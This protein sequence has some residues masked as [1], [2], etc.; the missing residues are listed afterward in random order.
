MDW[1]I[2]NQK[3]K[4]KKSKAGKNNVTDRRL[5]KEAREAMEA[6]RARQRLIRGAELRSRG[7]I[8]ERDDVDDADSPVEETQAPQARVVERPNSDG[9]GTEAEDHWLRFARDNRMIEDGDDVDLPDVPPESRSNGPKYWLA[10]KSSARRTNTDDKDMRAVERLAAQGDQDAQERLA[11]VRARHTGLIECW[12]G[13]VVTV[14]RMH[15][16]G[17]DAE[18]GPA[19]P[20]EL[21]KLCELCARSG[22]P[23]MDCDCDQPPS[24]EEQRLLDML[25]DDPDQDQDIEPR[26]NARRTR[27]RRN[28]RVDDSEGPTPDE[29]DAWQTWLLNAL[30]FFTEGCGGNGCANTMLNSDSQVRMT[31]PGD[32]GKDIFV[33]LEAR[34][35]DL[36]LAFLSV[37]VQVARAVVVRKQKI[38]NTTVGLQ[39][40]ADEVA[41]THGGVVFWVPFPM[42]GHLTPVGGT[43]GV[44][45]ASTIKG[46][47]FA[48]VF[49]G[50]E[51]ELREWIRTREFYGVSLLIMDEGWRMVAW[52]AVSATFPRLDGEEI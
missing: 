42:G 43:G 27:L 7:E 48:S 12:C 37:I 32:M 15:Y 35:M 23:G 46:E 25:P 9:R 11:R 5:R 33:A 4:K 30:P 6:E 49:V 14:G 28:K 3:K 20:A 1:S 45:F 44:L 52:G 38:I 24:D 21:G 2:G 16:P 17:L 40:I 22:D 41:K 19:H 8:V 47:A 51:V 29:R 18:N 13:S 34:E 31:R 36:Q 50:D 39:W 26:E 10:R